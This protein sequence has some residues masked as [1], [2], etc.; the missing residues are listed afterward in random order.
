MCYTEQSKKTERMILCPTKGE[1]NMIKIV[2]HVD[3]MQKWHLALENARNALNDQADAVV[4]VISNSEAVK[5]FARDYERPE[6]YS[7]LLE[8][9]VKFNACRNALR[10][11]DVPEDSI[12]AEV[13]VVSAGVVALAEKQNDGYAYIRP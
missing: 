3:E 7:E 10:G 5:F 6:I 4:E 9:G 8:R 13:N 12:P 11:N 1:I 2:F